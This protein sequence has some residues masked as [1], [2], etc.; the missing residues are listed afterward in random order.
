MLDNNWLQKMVCCNVPSS[1]G[2]C[3]FTFIKLIHD[4][5]NKQTVP[6]IVKTNQ[7]LKN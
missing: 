6:N 5:T 7:T 3:D 1:V 4:T 2:E